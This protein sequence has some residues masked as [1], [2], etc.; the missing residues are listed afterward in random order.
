MCEC[1]CV[2]IY[3][4]IYVYIC[5]Y[6]YIY[7]NVCMCVCVCVHMCVLLLFHHCC[8]VSFAFLSALLAS[9]RYESKAVAKDGIFVGFDLLTWAIIFCGSSLGI[10]STCVMCVMCVGVGV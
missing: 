8:L 5:I 9:R 3:I 10:S 6:I 4:Y 1:L 7:I 2:Y